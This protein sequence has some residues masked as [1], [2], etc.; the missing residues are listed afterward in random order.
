MSTPDLES[1]N[2]NRAKTR[3]LFNCPIFDA[4]IDGNFLAPHAGLQ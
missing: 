1:P 4:P 3:V 2:S